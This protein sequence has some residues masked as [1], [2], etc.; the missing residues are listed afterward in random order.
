METNIAGYIN[1]LEAARKNGVKNFIF[2]SS[3]A[4]YGSVSGVVSEKSKTNPENPYGLSKYIDEQVGRLYS[5]LYKMNI[6]GLR[7]ANV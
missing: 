4:V 6:I 2:A 7:F 5:D 3:A 1:I